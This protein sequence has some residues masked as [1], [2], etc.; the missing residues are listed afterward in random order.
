MYRRKLIKHYFVIKAHS[1]FSSW[2]YTVS[3][4]I[5]GAVGHLNSQ[6]NWELFRVMVKKW[7]SVDLL[8][9]MKKRSV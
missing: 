5:S 2:F 3:K 4:V 7:F 1:F 6:T 8:Y 9:Q